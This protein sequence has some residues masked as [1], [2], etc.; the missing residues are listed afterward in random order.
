MSMVR[1]D[2]AVLLSLLWCTELEASAGPEGGHRIFF[3]LELL[4]PRAVPLLAE[5]L[6][7]AP[8]GRCV[9]MAA[10][11]LLGRIGGRDAALALQVALR[12]ED[13]DV[14][15]AARSAFERIERRSRVA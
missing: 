7:T 9:R 3:L 6:A 13:A 8:Q 11:W 2:E 1:P 10:A 5:T 15:G 14:A 4:G 12:D